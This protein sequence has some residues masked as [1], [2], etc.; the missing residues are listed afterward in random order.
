MKIEITANEKL[1]FQYLL[2]NQGSLKILELTNGIIE[3]V[4]IIDRKEIEEN[5]IC[6]IDFNNDEI[7]FL[8]Q[9]IKILDESNKLNLQSLTLI[10]KIL[11]LKGEKI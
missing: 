6:S 1:Q 10:K 7:D 3:K 9:N 2:P 8:N 5:K 11:K 4:K